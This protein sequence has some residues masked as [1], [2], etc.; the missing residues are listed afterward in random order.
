M[1]FNECK[2]VELMIGRSYKLLKELPLIGTMNGKDFVCV[3][4]NPE[5][6]NHLVGTSSQSIVLYKLIFLFTYFVLENGDLRDLLSSFVFSFFFLLFLVSQTLEENKEKAHN[7]Q[8][9][10]KLH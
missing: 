7:S 10:L 1:G 9:N 8:L 2:G 4:E 5:P 3:F 6:H